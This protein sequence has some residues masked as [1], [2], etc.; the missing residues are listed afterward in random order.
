MK[1]G[2]VLE[3]EFYYFNVKKREG[4]EEEKCDEVDDFIKISTC[5]CFS[6]VI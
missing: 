5:Y 2:N 6:L 1:F 3:K 4:E